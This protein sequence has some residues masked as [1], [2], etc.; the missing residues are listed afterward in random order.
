MRNNKRTSIRVKW[1]RAAGSWL[2]FALIVF[3]SGCQSMNPLPNFGL[4]QASPEES[5]IRKLMKWHSGRVEVY[6]EFRTVF[7]ARA[8]YLSEDIQSSVVDFESRSKLL[9][10]EERMELEK[11][12]NGGGDTIKVL[13]G[14]YTPNEEFNDLVSD[15]AAWVPYLTKPDGTVIRAACFSVGEEDA[16]VYMRFLEWDLSWS[17]LYMLCFPYDPGVHEPDDGWIDL[18]ISGSHG[19]GEVRLKTAPLGNIP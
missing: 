14:F 16:K 2:L 13:L 1:G 7:T 3:V 17:K 8:V 6:R 15:E 18:V 19:R 9:S 11:R 12:I 5:R 4:G 10:P